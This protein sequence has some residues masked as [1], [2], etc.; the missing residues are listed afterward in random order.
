MVRQL[1]I[2]GLEGGQDTGYR[3]GGSALDVVVEGAVGVAVL[4][5][6]PEGVV[7]TKVLKL[8]QGVLAVPL[9]YSLHEL[10][11]KVVVLGAGHTLLPEADVVHVLQEV[12]VVCSH[13]KG[14]G[15]GLRGKQIM[16]GRVRHYGSRA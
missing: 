7:V 11:H 2:S 6:Q 4:F 9:Y 12:L 15:Q 1:G 8:D 16:L 3:H 13:V 14:D 5:Q 10:L